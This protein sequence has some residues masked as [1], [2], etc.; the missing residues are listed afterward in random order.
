MNPGSRSATPARE[1]HPAA[2]DVSVVLST[3][4]RGAL[5]KNALEKLLVQETDGIHY[6]ILIVDNNSTDQTEQ[7][8]R[9]YMERD[10]HFRYVFERRQGL[11]FARNAGI[12][13]ARADL[14]VFCDDDVEAS[15]NWIQ[16]NYQASLRFPDAD[17][18]GG[19]V[20]PIWH[21]SP[22]RW[23]R[24]TTAPLA[25]S[26]LGDQAIIVSPQKPHCMIGASLA[27][28]RR[29]LAKAGLFSIETQRIKDGIG[30]TEDFDWQMKVWAYG[31]HGAYVP[32]IVCA[33]PVPAH[34]LSKSYHRRWHFC[35]G[36]FNAMGQRPAWESPSRLF[37]VP[38]FMYRQ[39]V[40]AALKMIK[41][42]F[43]AHE[44]E[45]FGWQM[46]AL[47]LIGFVKQSWKMHLRGLPTVGAH[48]ARSFPAAQ[49]DP[50]APRTD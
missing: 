40:E 36:K 1:K 24:L 5:L 31:G 37:G 28:R 29:A 42:L 18:F 3:Y 7:L 48:T 41:N 9:S 38:L 10:T 21:C 2:P 30:S 46:N 34:R 26:D 47:F 11:S 25:L 12:Q 20:L 32:E 45:A 19:R 22:P 15:P 35:H 27:V 50:Y 43:L 4:N 14:I 8:V 39:A 49:P 17:Y 33:T 16:Q 13:A 6:E 44:A 23:I